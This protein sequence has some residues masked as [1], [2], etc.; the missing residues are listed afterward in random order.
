MLTALVQE[1]PARL[2]AIRQTGASF[3][4]DHYGRALGAISLLQHE[5]VNGLKLDKSLTAQLTENSRI[6][7]M[8]GALAA[9]GKSLQLRV[10]AEGVENSAQRMLVNQAECNTIQGHALGEPLSPDA[11]QQLLPGSAEALC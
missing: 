4:I 6:R 5:F 10:L 1:V 8:F 7:M 9:L 2:N 3:I 11:F